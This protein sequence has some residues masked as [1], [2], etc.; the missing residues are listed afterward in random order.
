MASFQSLVC[1]PAFCTGGFPTYMNLTSVWIYIA[2]TSC[3]I[4][5]ATAHTYSDAMYLQQ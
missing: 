1:G 5:A 4:V 2:Y 3:G